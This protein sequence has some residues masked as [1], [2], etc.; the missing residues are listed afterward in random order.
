[1]RIIL[2]LILLSGCS[3]LTYDERFTLDKVE[4]TE[5]KVNIEYK[6]IL[7]RGGVPV[8]GYAVWTASTCLI[9]LKRGYANACL[10]H[11]MLHCIYGQWHDEKYNGEFCR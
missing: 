1:M 8:L 7:I 5:F 3:S 2:C 6:D 10:L 11:E 4:R 9:T